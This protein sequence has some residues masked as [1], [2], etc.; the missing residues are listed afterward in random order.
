MGLLNSIRLSADYQDLL[1]AGVVAVEM[2]APGEPASLMP[3]ESA[4]LGRA[5]PK[6]QQEF[7]AGRLCA[8]RALSA[9]GQGEAAIRVGAEREPLWPQGFVGSI[10]HTAGLAAAAVAPAELCRGLGIDVERSAELGVHLWPAICVRREI[11]WLES[12]PAA[13]RTPAAAVVFAAKEAFYKAQFPT[14]RQRV[15]FHDVAI[16]LGEWQATQGEFLVRPLRPLAVTE[17]YGLPLQGRYRV[18]GEL[19][20]TGLAL[21]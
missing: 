9:W 1:P 4:C 3:E 7:A 14:T 19:I 11:D 18:R 17:V 16:E 2:S 20:L 13:V 6:R 10:T 12:L 8:R 15:G 21:R 5:V